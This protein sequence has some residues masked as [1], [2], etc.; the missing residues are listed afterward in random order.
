M[1]AELTK[2]NKSLRRNHHLDRKA[3]LLINHSPSGDPNTLFTTQETAK[4]LRTSTQ[5]LE[6]GRCKNYGPPFVQLGPLSIRY[7]KAD[8][9]KWLEQRLYHSTREYG[10]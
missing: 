7:R 8:V 10:R 4:W 1:E 5:W 2:S 6:I 9:V 3:D